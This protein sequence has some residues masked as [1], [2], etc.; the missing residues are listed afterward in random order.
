MSIFGILISVGVSF[1]FTLAL[2]YVDRDNRSLDKVKKYIGIQKEDLDEKFN[3]H[4]AR[5]KNEYNEVEVK[6]TQAIATVRNLEDKIGEFDQ[7]THE[8]DTRIQAVDAIDSKIS[9]YDETLRQLVEMTAN[10]EEN[11]RRVGAES[12]VVDKLEKQMVVYQKN[13]SAI[14]GRISRLTADFAEENGK[15]LKQ[16]GAELLKRFSEQVEELEASTE[17]AV[18]RNEDALRHISETVADIYSN[19]AR[20]AQSLEDQSFVQ[21]QDR[22]QQNINELQRAFDEALEKLND[23]TNVRVDNLQ[24]YLTSQVA[25][26]RGDLDERSAELGRLSSQLA[27]EASSNSQLLATVQESLA[28]RSQELEEEYRAAYDRVRSEI[29]DQEAQALDSFSSIS[30]Q[31]H[32]RVQDDLQSQLDQARQDLEAAINATRQDTRERLDGI[33]QELASRMSEAEDSISSAV[34]F[35]QQ[36]TEQVSS[37]AGENNSSLDAVQQ[38]FREPAAKLHLQL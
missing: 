27:Q 18:T 34:A 22:T 32:E 4:I 9:A 6:Q 2:R 26:L 28:I 17:D 11:M 5:L 3:G 31:N 16:M 29:A 36:V 30:T 21:L 13:V 15:Q 35:A 33:E 14:E 7:L 10:L 19:A 37:L 8:F 24:D 1:V 38:D 23:D 25:S 12:S 20:K